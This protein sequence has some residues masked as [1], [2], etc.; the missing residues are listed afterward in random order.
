MKLLFAF[1]LAAAVPSTTEPVQCEIG[2][3]YPSNDPQRVSLRVPDK[4]C[5]IEG[6]R[7]ALAKMTL[8]LNQ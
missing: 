6:M 2:V 5:N 8:L 7:T 3:I 1:V 4:R